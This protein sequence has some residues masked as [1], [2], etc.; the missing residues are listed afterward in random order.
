MDS[1]S[2]P[3]D[4][5]SP[6]HHRTS[7]P[8]VSAGD[9][10][11]RLAYSSLCALYFWLCAASQSILSNT[12]ASDDKGDDDRLPHDSFLSIGS[13]DGL[14]SYYSKFVLWLIYSIL[15]DMVVLFLDRFDAKLFGFFQHRIFKQSWCIYS[16]WNIVIIYTNCAWIV[17]I[18]ERDHIV[19]RFLP[20]YDRCDPWMN[21]H[22]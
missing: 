22:C 4:G 7:D 19:I 14:N 11:C 16:T 3:V 10:R 13:M 6:F 9:L 18:I 8:M 5:Y 2:C 15:Y 1:F 17:L 21:A 12:M 20:I